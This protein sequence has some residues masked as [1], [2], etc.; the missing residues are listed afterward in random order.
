MRPALPPDALI[1]IDI[2][3]QLT[4]ADLN[5]LCDATDAA[6]EAGGGFGWITP[7]AREVMERYWKGVMVV[8]ERHLLLARIDG[9]VCGAVQL[10]EPSRHNEAQAFSATLLAAFIAPWA[11]GR[12]AGRKLTEMA[13]KL[14]LEMGYKVLQLDVRA[15]QEAAIHLYESLGYIR[16]GVNPAYAHIDGQIVAGHY[17]AKTIAPVLKPAA[18]A[19]QTPDRGK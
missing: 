10:V 17:Y 1:S 16:W 12:G 3:D 15:S 8:P 4:P 14:A 2:V 13:E 7:P 5:D 11:R 6:V 19:G 9:V 18:G